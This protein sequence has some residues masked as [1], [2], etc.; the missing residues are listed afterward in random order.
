MISKE[1]LHIHILKEI[2]GP[3]QWARVVAEAVVIL[4]Q[5]FWTFKTSPA[6]LG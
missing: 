4:Q 2:Q 6:S 1:W 3:S 5:A